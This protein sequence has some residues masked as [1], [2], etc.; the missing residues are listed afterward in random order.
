MGAIELAMTVCVVGTHRIGLALTVRK[1]LKAAER[2]A[3][4]QDKSHDESS[5]YSCISSRFSSKHND[6]FSMKE[7][8]HV[9]VFYGI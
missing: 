2:S 1:L 7:K 5:Y 6:T 4:S 3:Y 9:N 8:F